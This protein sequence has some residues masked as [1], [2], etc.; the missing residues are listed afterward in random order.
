MGVRRGDGMN[1]LVDA[2]SWVAMRCTQNKYL[3]AIKNTFQNYMPISL[4]GA[5]GIFWINVLVN[6]HGGLGTVFPLIMYLKIF[7]P[8]FEALNYAAIS[9]ISIIIVLLLS[10]ELLRRM[11]IMIFIL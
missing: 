6:D 2:L 8:I 10:S 9:C 4:T 11:V 5:V 7:N 1:K 3:N